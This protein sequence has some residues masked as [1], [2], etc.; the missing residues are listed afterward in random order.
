MAVGQGSKTSSKWWIAGAILSGQLTVSFGMFAVVVAL[1]KIMTSF[2]ADLNAIQ[3]VMTGYLI[4]RAVPM[5]ALGWL[6]SLLGKRNL[7]ILGVVGATVCTTLCGLAWSIESLI[8]FRVLQGA[9]GAPAMGIGVVLLYEAFPANQRG[10]AMGLILLVGSLGPTIGPSLGGYLVQEISWRAIFF[11]ALPSGFACILLTLA[12]V[13][14]DAPVGGKTIDI[15]GL[16]TMTVF[17][18]TLLLAL[19]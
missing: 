9:L 2:G 7:Y 6:T 12:I 10:M 19:A 14:S 3:W 11:L 17:L 4:A 15:P 13:P 18:V 1:P 8:F 16:L 5:P